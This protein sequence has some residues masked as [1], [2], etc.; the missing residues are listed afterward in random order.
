MH[1]PDLRD[2]PKH[3]PDILPFHPHVNQ[4]CQVPLGEFHIVALLLGELI[5][6]LG[7]DKRSPSVL[8]GE[9]ITPTTNMGEQEGEKGGEVV[10]EG[11]G[12]RS[13]ESS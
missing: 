3:L 11:W 2:H 6:E 8:D 13:Y 9:Q 5:R 1:P 7:K 10:L 12:W 4:H